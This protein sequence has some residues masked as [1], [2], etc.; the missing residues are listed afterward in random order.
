LLDSNEGAIGQI[1]S[2]I[3]TAGIGGEIFEVTLMDAPVLFRIGQASSRELTREN[4][5]KNDYA[6]T[7]K[8]RNWW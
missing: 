7:V 2:S 8:M 3:H 6:K 5:E 4:E 1:G